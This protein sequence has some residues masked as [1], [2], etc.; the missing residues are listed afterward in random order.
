M[1]NKDIVCLPCK[2]GELVKINNELW[3]VVGFEC[4]EVGAWRVKL[5]CFKDQFRDSYKYKKIL[6]KNFEELRK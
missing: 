1:E 6:F 5:R 3:N 4:N 2:L